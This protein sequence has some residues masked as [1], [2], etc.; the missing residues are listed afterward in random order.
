MV[1]IVYRYTL[2]VTNSLFFNEIKHVSNFLKGDTIHVLVVW[3][4]R[5]SV[6]NNYIYNCF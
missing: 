6:L 2:T 3:Y 5:F 4:V 1:A